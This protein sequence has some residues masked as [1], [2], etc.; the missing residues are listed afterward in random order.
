VVLVLVG[1]FSMT[2][3]TIAATSRPARAAANGCDHADS[4]T[5]TYA[6][7][8]CWFDMAGFDQAQAQTAAG[9][10]FS[11]TLD[12]GYT[13]TFNVIDHT[14]TGRTSRTIDAVVPPAFDAHISGWNIFGTPGVYTGIEGRPV[15]YSDPGAALGENAIT[16]RDITVRDSSGTEVEGF[17]IVSVDAEATS[18]SE[19]LIWQSDVPLTRIDGVT[20]NQ[21]QGC[22]LSP[23]GNGTTTMTC[24]GLSSGGHFATMVQASAPSTFTTTMRETNTGERQGVAFG[25][26]TAQVEVVKAVDSRLSPSDSFD[27][28]ITSPQSTVLGS[29]TTGT[30]DT[31]TTGRT[32]ILPGVAGTDSFVLGETATPGSGTALSDYSK[33]WACVNT[34]A[35]ST[36]ALPTGVG[37]HVGVVPVPGDDITCT[38][39]NTAIQGPAIELAK[40]VDATKLVAGRT[41][42]YTFTAT[43]T[44]NNTLSRV[45]IGEDSFTGSG[46]MPALSCTPS[47]PA[48]LARAARLVCTATY[49]VTPADVAAG[50]VDNVASATGADPAGTV[51]TDQD[52]ATVPATS[53]AGL[54]IHK[55]VAS[56]TDVN[57]NGS[58]DLGDEINF[59]FEVTNTGNVALTKVGV[60]DPL[61]GAVICDRTTLAAHAVMRCEPHAP[62]AISQADVDA[63]VVHNVA[64]ASGTPPSGT[65]VTSSPG[66]TETRVARR[67]AMTLDKRVSGVTDV[68]GNGDTDTGDEVAFEFEVT[69]TGTTTLTEVAVDDP[70]LAAH[71]IT[72][73]CDRSTLAPDESVVCTADSP[74]AV[75]AA[76][77]AH[78][79]VHNIAAATAD[80]PQGVDA[81]APA[82]DALDHMTGPTHD[83]TAPCDCTLPD[84]GAPVGLW[85]WVTGG[86]L[87][88]AAGSVVLTR[89]S[90]G[91]TTD[92]VQP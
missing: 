44:G 79:R 22:P 48:T 87:L 39:T 66:E 30:S 91:H 37:T 11:V 88:M 1:G 56:I 24:T 12:G 54:E 19:E 33:S 38:V 61:V 84:T 17:A 76:D 67:A 28:S 31:A 53:V 9:Q 14:G 29:A 74:Y 71:G 90:R 72:T 81:P 63:G 57:R 51:V 69:N 34:N 83:D 27:V 20:A 25:I 85:W 89:G 36:T 3:V 6:D 50:E 26:M 58:A 55:R 75:T 16:L 59:S 82:Q 68:N 32:T 62:Y 23:P 43:N 7:T 18:P 13:A 64:T 70:K 8:I 15:L 40:T 46:P 77:V 60:S 2:G 10:G 42:T 52:D 21:V 35:A 78:G 73:T 65:I 41:L 4:G 49:T 80:A 47:Q 86:V 5:G 45:V 92:R